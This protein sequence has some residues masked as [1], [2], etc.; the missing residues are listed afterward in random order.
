MLRD[1]LHVVDHNVNWLGDRWPAMI[2]ISL[3]G[4]WKG[5]G[6]SMLIFLAALTGV[7][8]ELH[9]AAVH[10]RRRRGARA[11]VTSRSRSSPARSPRS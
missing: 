8:R 10:R 1:V 4:I 6:W 9:E 5:V 11:S 3:L 2:A 7:P